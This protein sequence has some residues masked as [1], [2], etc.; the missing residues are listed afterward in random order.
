MKNPKN[1]QIRALER[2]LKHAQAQAVCAADACVRAEALRL[3][4]VYKTALLCE[5][6]EALCEEEEG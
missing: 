4:G 1:S 6:M 2:A 5:R 3:V